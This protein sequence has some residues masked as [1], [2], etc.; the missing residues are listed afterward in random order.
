MVKKKE[1]ISRRKKQPASKRE[2]MIVKTFVYITIIF[3]S[4]LILAAVGI[5]IPFI[6]KYIFKILVTIGI[7]LGVI[8]AFLIGIV[9]TVT[10]L[11]SS[12]SLVYILIMSLFKGLIK[13]VLEFFFG[14]WIES[15]RAYKKF[16]EWRKKFYKKIKRK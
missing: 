11:L 7:V 13:K 14:G 16:D 9:G 4:L 2:I 12:I 15:T 5:E 10:A 8:S 3:I 1:L 6:G